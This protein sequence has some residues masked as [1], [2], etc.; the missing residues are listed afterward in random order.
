[1]PVFILIN[2]HLFTVAGCLSSGSRCHYSSNLRRCETSPRGLTH[3]RDP[4]PH[5]VHPP[6]TYLYS[7]P[8]QASTQHSC[9][10]RRDRRVRGVR[11]NDSRLHDLGIR[12]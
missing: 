7:P 4:S 3:G 1:M 9:Q 5:S 12:W 11:C 10:H 2:W 6:V 8:A